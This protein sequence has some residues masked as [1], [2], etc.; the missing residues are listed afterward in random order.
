M[1]K[2]G[3]VVVRRHGREHFIGKLGLVDSYTEEVR[4]GELARIW[5]N[6]GQLAADIV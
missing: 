4:K 3:V 2:N 1:E 6:M 5:G